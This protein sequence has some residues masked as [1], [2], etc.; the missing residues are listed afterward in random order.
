LFHAFVDVFQHVQEATALLA[1]L[2]LALAL[3]LHETGEAHS[4]IVVLPPEVLDLIGISLKALL[5]EL[6]LS[7]CSNLELVDEVLNVPKECGHVVVDYFTAWAPQRVSAQ[8]FWEDCELQETLSI[9][10]MV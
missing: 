4:A 8:I 1:T 6:L 7:L 9:F 2:C 3:L 5:T 10:G